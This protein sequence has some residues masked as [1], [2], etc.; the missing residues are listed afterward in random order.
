MKEKIKYVGYGICVA[1]IVWIALSTIEVWSHN[2]EKDY[3]YNKANVWVLTTTHTTDMVVVDCQGNYDDTY[4]VTVKD[5]EGNL[6]AYY[7]DCPKETGD[8]LSIT[9]SGEQIINATER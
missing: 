5:I 4:E 8:I 7:D 2:L 6:W 3:E 1:F 9:M